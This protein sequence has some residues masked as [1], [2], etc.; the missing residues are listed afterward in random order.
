LFSLPLEHRPFRELKGADVAAL[1]DTIED[2]SGP[3]QADVCL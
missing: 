2:K 3:R 1:L